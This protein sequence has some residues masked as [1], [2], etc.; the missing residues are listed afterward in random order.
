MSGLKTV[1]KPSLT[2][3]WTEAEFYPSFRFVP[4]APKNAAQDPS[5]KG[6][7][8]SFEEALKKLE[9]I[10]E[11]MESEDLPLEGLLAKYEEGTQLTKTCQDKLAEAELKIQ[12]LEKSPS[13][14][15]KLKP[16]ASAESE[17]E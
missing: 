12:K 8:L 2:L 7:A 4:N 6:G 10:V 17:A 5:G 11:A 3:D 9:A 1:V 13:G 16:L 15:M 14:E